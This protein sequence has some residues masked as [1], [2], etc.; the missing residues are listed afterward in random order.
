MAAAF[1]LMPAEPRLLASLFA[2]RTL[3]ETAGTLGITWPP[4]KT[5]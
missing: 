4:A 1:G 5:H 2:G 3:I